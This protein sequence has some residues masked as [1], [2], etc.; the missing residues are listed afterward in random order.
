MQRTFNQGIDMNSD[1]TFYTG[2]VDSVHGAQMQMHNM[3]II[4]NNLA[5][6]NTSGFKSDRLLFNEE[7]TRKLQTYFEQGNI[8]TT[9][10]PL[11]VAISGEGFFQ[12]KTKEGVRLTRDGA[13]L[14]LGDGS[15]VS[16]SGDPVLDEGGNPI[17]L[18]PQGG[19]PHIDSAGQ[20]MQGSEIVAKL[21]VMDVDLEAIR[22]MGHNLFGPLEG[23]TLK[24]KPSQNYD[25]QQG[26]LEMPNTTIVR[27]MVSMISS[28]RAFESYQKVMHAF[29][30]MD[31]KAV[32]QVGKLA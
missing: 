11:D 4:S 5:N 22:K 32:N 28:F 1:F 10:N 18:N 26:A 17:A 13:F 12:V 19:Q 15:L 2:L 14:M 27:E 25:L 7:M 24:A 3:E 8:K 29:S 21:G 30:E 20:V 6:A 23:Q 9:N 31:S 16:S